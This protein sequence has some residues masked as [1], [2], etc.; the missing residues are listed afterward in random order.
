MSINLQSIGKVCPDLSQKVRVCATHAK[1]DLITCQYCAAYACDCHATQCRECSGLFCV[2]V[3]TKL[4][5]SRKPE[6]FG[7][8]NIYR[9]C[10]ELNLLQVLCTYLFSKL[11]SFRVFKHKVKTLNKCE[12]CAFKLYDKNDSSACIRCA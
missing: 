7:I 2:G 11:F 10:R 5:L 9:K 4:S 3:A 12:D 6:I 8:E 1:G